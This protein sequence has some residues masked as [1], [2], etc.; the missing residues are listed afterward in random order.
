[1]AMAMAVGRTGSGGAENALRGIGR[2]THTNTDD[3]E[4][5]AALEQLLLDLG[6]DAVE[7]DEALGEH[8]LGQLRVHR[9]RGHGWCWWWWWC[10]RGSGKVVK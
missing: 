10:A 1:M 3:I 7:A 8:A 6:G 2:C 5:K 9:R 4:L